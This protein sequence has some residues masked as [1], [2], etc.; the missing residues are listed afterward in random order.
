MPAF[1]DQRG[2][3]KRFGMGKLNAAFFEC[4]DP[5]AQRLAQLAVNGEAGRNLEQRRVQVPQLVGGDGGLDR[6]ARGAV[7]FAGADLGDGRILVD[8]GVHLLA[9]LVESLFE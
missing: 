1:G 6:R 8:P 2:E 5:A 3:G 4:F 7:E 9:Q